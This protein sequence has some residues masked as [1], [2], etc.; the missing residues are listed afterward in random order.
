MEDWGFE[1][2]PRFVQ[3]NSKKAFSLGPLKSLGG[4]SGMSWVDFLMDSEGPA[5][6]FW[7]IFY[8]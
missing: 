4:E 2:L 7:P 6:F 5:F 3:A 8:A 1:I